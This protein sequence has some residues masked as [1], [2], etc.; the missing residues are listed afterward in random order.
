ME[1]QTIAQAV[2]EVLKAAKQPMSTAE[3][4]QI[5]LDKKLYEFS[6]KDPKSI[7]R[8]AIERRCEGLNRKDS[9][10]PP[11]FKKVSGGKYTLI[12]VTAQ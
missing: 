8:G 2:V 10:N 11:Y 3:I 5:I 1:K 4:T 6:A 12:E 7:V 9:I